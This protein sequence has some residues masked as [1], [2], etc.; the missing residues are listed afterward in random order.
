MIPWALLLLGAC[1]D[2]T[3][4]APAVPDLPPTARA[5]L[6]RMLAEDRAAVRH[7]SD[8]GG[9]ARLVEGTPAVAG[10]TGTWTLS[11]TTGPLGIAEGG[12][13]FLQVSP[14]WGWSS[15]QVQDPLGAGFTEVS[16]TAPGV[17]LEPEG[18]G[19]QLLAVRVRGRALE[20]GEAVGFRYGAGPA[21]ALAD[22]YAEGASRF[23]FGVDGDG[24]GVRALLPDAPSVAVAPGPA[25]GILATLPSTARPGEEVRL[26]VAVLDGQ[27]NAGVRFEGTLALDADPALE[28]PSEIRIGPADG[29]T[30]WVSARVSGE[31]TARVR[32]SGPG[33]LAGLSNPILIS[34]AVPR[35][36]WGDPHGHGDL[37]DGTGRPA[38]WYRYAQDVAALDFAALTE[39]DHWGPWPLDTRPD[40]WA[41]IQAAARAAHE[42]GRFVTFVG[43]EWTSWIHGHRHVLFPGDGGTMFSSLSEA[44]DT[45]AE[46]VEALRPL[47]AVAIPH[48]PAG[49]PVAVDASETWDPEVVPVVE[50]ASVHGSSEADDVPGAIYDAVP[51]RWVRELVASG[52]APGFVGGGDG[53][54][55]HPGLAQLAGG[56]GG[57]TAVLDADLTREGILS[58]FRTHRVYATNGPRIVLFT[59][60]DGHPMGSLVAVSGEAVLR[61]F[62]LGTTDLDAVDVVRSGTV[63]PLDAG[64]QA[65]FEGTVPLTG[66]EPGETVYV[67]VRQVDGGMAW[68]SPFRIAP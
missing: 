16:T 55:G 54:D 58:A 66:F 36:L 24:D 33:G 23:W 6:V 42:P 44:T 9:S 61:I 5:D 22:R 59:T 56:R 43:Y 15:P 68:S 31:G 26:A 29:G 25:A 13:L 10:R 11:Y 46:L 28:V 34:A 50:V 48:H 35:V 14:F 32:V 65:V 3:R 39:H 20:E 17:V 52:T 45:P 63:T 1:A 2:S 4:N 27:G 41:E 18:L 53:H 37:S 12:M 21:G 64:R 51:G 8:G 60:L 30:A 7:P 40:L 49:G 67:R 62:A 19:T 47:G 57:V 38:D